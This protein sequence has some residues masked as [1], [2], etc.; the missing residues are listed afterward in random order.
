MARLVVEDS[1]EEFPV[2]SELVVIPKATMVVVRGYVDSGKS[3]KELGGRSQENER[4]GQGLATESV[5]ARPRKRVLNKASDNPLL[6][7]IAG[8]GNHSSIDVEDKVGGNNRGIAA[9]SRTHPTV[10]TKANTAPKAQMLSED[11]VS[12]LDIDAP[13][14]NEGKALWTKA[15]IYP[16]T[17]LR[18]DEKTKSNV[19][20]KKSRLSSQEG[21]TNTATRISKSAILVDSE[22]DCEN[23]ISDG[24][25]EFIVDDSTFLAEG[26]SIINTKPSR[27]VRR[28]VKG[29]RRRSHDDSD[30]SEL[31]FQLT[32]LTMKEDIDSP[33]DDTSDS[34]ILK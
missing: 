29:R 9:K 14:I 1:D 3:M 23:D 16:A 18:L 32:R 33:L 24:L 34:F 4:I 6:R 21:R 11:V 17:S 10:S 22:D 27:S 2:L 19:A 8:R 28:L 7:P 31:D 26:D 13:G 15:E 12:A 5:K 20:E 30:H 25:S